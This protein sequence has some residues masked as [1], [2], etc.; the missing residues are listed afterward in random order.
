MLKF[1]GKFKVGEVIQ[2]YD[3]MPGRSDVADS[4]IIGRIVEDDNMEHGF[5]AYKVMQLEH[6]VAGEQMIS[7]RGTMAWIPMEVSIMEYD[8]RIQKVA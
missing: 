8:N 6:I 5:K 4:F 3:F 1:E 7:D 2:A